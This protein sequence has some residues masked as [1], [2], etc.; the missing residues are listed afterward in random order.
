M[1]VISRV[2]I[3]TENDIAWI[4]K[5]YINL[6]KLTTAPKGYT[7]PSGNY[8]STLMQI[9]RAKSRMLARYIFLMHEKE[10]KECELLLKFVNMLSN[11]YYYLALRINNN[12]E[13]ENLIYRK[14]AD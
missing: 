6:R 1:D 4:E 5:E 3:I 8:S 7:M 14:F 13:E 10:N 11:L 12:H 2:D 9:I